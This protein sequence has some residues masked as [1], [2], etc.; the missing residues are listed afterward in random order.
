MLYSASSLQSKASFIH[1]I[2]FL[3]CILGRQYPLKQTGAKENLMQIRTPA[4]TETHALYLY[5]CISQKALSVENNCLKG[6][7][8]S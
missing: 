7:Q 8:A 3:V 6:T 2:S 4:A 1:I 5:K